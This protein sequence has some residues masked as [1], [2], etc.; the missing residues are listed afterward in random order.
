MHELLLTFL[1]NSRV[2]FPVASRCR[3]C[4]SSGEHEPGADQPRARAPAEYW[5]VVGQKQPSPQRP[6]IL[7]IAKRSSSL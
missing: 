3:R 5:N 7:S 1:V 6:S 2:L 4:A